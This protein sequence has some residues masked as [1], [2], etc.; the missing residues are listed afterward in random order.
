MPTDK[1]KPLSSAALKQQNK[2]QTQQVKDCQE[3]IKEMKLLFE[4]MY[5]LKGQSGV[6]GTRHAASACRAQPRAPRAA[7]RPRVRRQRV[8]RRTAGAAHRRL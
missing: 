6:V 3:D 8:T 5:F 7:A 4:R 1:A 2:P